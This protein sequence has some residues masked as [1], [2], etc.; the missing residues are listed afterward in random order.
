MIVW[1]VMK[2]CIYDFFENSVHHEIGAKQSKIYKKVKGDL[3]VRQW[4]KYTQL[5]D[6]NVRTHLFRFFQSIGF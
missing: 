1:K 5:Y 2:I 6:S 4:K 3:L